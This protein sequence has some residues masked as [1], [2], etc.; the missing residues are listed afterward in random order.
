[1]WKGP[2]LFEPSTCDLRS[3]PC[4]I[5]SACLDNSFTQSINRAVRSRGA[6]S[7]SR[8]W[9]KTL[10]HLKAIRKV[11]RF[12]RFHLIFGNSIVL[13]PPSI[14]ST[15]RSGCLLNPHDRL[16]LR[17]HRHRSRSTERGFGPGTIQFRHEIVVRDLS[18]A[19]ALPPVLVA[20][21]YC[22]FP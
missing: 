13:H 15:L 6:S 21:F 8:C 14:H 12:F 4:Q 10:C 9:T 17:N 16:I 11:S 18:S 19:P 5:S 2:S 3:S 22:R 20:K 7:D 1:M